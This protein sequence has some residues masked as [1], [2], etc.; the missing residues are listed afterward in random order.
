[1]V[2]KIVAMKKFIGTKKGGDW[3]FGNGKSGGIQ[4]RKWLQ[5][6]DSNDQK[7]F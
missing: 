2:T 7:L 3:D 1:M 4:K 6:L 5:S